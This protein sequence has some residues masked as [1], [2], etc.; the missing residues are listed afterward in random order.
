MLEQIEWR[1]TLLERECLVQIE[2]ISA[3]LQ[4]V[5]HLGERIRL[6]ETKRAKQIE[7]VGGIEGLANVEGLANRV[8][9]L[10]DELARQIE[11]ISAEIKVTTGTT[12]RLSELSQQVNAIAKARRGLFR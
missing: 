6:L 11:R 1:L 12:A 9:S 8:H 7:R 2:R 10:E 3:G 4:D 5:G